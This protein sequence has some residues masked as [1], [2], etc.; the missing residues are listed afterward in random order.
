MRGSTLLRQE[1]IWFNCVHCHHLI[2]SAI[3]ISCKIHMKH[4]DTFQIVEEA[5]VDLLTLVELSVRGINLILLGLV[6]GWYDLIRF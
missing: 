4:V 6:I 1:V 2:G 3:D 5:V